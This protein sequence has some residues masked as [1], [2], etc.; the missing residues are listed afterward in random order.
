MSKPA[1]CQ[2]PPPTVSMQGPTTP[3]LYFYITRTNGALV[4]LI[5]ADELPLDVKL[6][7]VPR[8]LNSD[9]VF[10]LTS[11][12]ELPSTGLTFKLV[13]STQPLSTPALRS[14]TT[15]AS[16]TAPSAAPDETT[17]RAITTTHSCHS[18]YDSPRPTPAAHE[19]A[20]TW[21]STPKPTPTP[22]AQSIINA[23]LDTD[24]GAST[25]AKIGYIPDSRKPIPPSGA[26]PDPEKKTYCSHWIR[27]GECDY[28]QQG[29]RYRHEMPDRATL[30]K[31]G[32]RGVPKWWA[33]RNVVVRL[34]AEGERGGGAAGERPFGWAR[35]GGRVL[36]GVDGVS[37][38][39]S[40]RGS[41]VSEA[42]SVKLTAVPVVPRAVSKVTASVTKPVR[43][44]E[45]K[46]VPTS[47]RVVPSG[48]IEVDLIDF[49]PLIPAPA[50]ASASAPVASSS[51]DKADTDNATPSPASNS[52]S[53]TTST[54]K[55]IL[56]P[57]NAFIAAGEH[58]LA[59]IANAAQAKATPPATSS[60]PRPTHPE[61]KTTQLVP[62]ARYNGGLM[63]SRFAVPQGPAGGATGPSPRGYKASPRSVTAAQRKHAATL[64][65][66]D[67]RSATASG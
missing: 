7:G 60:P 48:S 38:A 11:V 33:E 35:T 65:C 23:I 59:Q 62:R 61:A 34:P 37:S 55:T 4:P 44:V 1:L 36:D 46:E 29:C 14:P 47:V 53:V 8:A 56:S 67:R 12:G 25:A 40:S 19:T 13:A 42:A 6:Q 27:H 2:P 30:L 5:P 10:A 18:S 52:H 16:M 24:A 66:R 54:P 32:F 39:S 31:I 51:I 3:R 45:V 17:R 28:T 50:P 49:E 20:T 15:L 58:P 63:A 43:P 41:S 22:T 9:Q 21:R 26:L 57:K 64:G